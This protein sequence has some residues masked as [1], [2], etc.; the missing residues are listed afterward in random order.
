MIELDLGLDLLFGL[1]Q[2]DSLGKAKKQRVLAKEEGILRRAKEDLE[3]QIKEAE[4]LL[5]VL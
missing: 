5:S 1:M 4:S 2:L 3:I